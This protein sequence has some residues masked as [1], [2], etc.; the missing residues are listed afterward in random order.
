MIELEKTYLVKELP[1]KIE[2]FEHK[3]IFDIYIPKSSRH[4][5]I[6]IRRNGNRHEITKKIHLN[7]DFNEFKEYT[8]PISKE[9]FDALEKE[10]EGK[11]VRKIR[12]NMPYKGLIAEIDVFQDK[13]KGLAVIEF[14]YPDRKTRD[15]F[16][17]PDFCGPDVTAEEFVAG[18]FIC[19]K[20]YE[21]IKPNLEKY[22]YKK[23]KH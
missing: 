1:K 21:E 8:I 13:L 5:E 16:E 22:G 12:Y 18:G 3:E 15:S 2:E 14:E 23:I 20:T 6:R 11:R 10:I 19:G 7:D 4:A 9:E 17:H